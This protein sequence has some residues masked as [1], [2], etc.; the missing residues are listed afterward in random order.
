M[1]AASGA[2]KL[3]H[4]FCLLN[5]KIVSWLVFWEM[6]DTHPRSRIGILGLTYSLSALKTCSLS[7]HSVRSYRSP[8]NLLTQLLHLLLPARLYCLLFGDLLLLQ[9]RL[10]RHLS[11]RGWVCLSDTASFAFQTEVE[12]PFHPEVKLHRIK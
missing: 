12:I 8:P 9:G 6:L 7:S 1:H 11:N 4:L 2:I 3:L 5:I 10:V